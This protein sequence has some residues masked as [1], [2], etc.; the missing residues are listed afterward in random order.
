[1]DKQSFLYYLGIAFIATSVTKLIPLI[2]ETT[3]ILC[4]KSKH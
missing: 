3:R 4:R 1:M 2:T